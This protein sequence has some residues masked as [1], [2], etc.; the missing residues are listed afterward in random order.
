M[1]G[2]FDYLLPD[3]AEVGTLL[4]VPFGGQKLTA[5]VTGLADSSEHKLSAPLSVHDASVPADLVDLGMWIAREYASTPGRALSLVLPPKGTRPKTAK[6]ASLTA[7]GE[8]ALTEFS[9]ERLTDGQR[10]AMHALPA[11]AGDSL[12]LLRR[13][14]GRGLVMI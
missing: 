6:W 13:L 2:P 10:A 9:Q 3:G 7:S 8:A 12:A 5:V 11:P 4:E 14:E 1:R